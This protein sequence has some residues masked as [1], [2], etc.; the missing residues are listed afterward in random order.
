MLFKALLALGMLALS[1]TALIGPSIPL[2][3]TL[4]SIPSVSSSVHNICPGS[5]SDI[6]NQIYTQVDSLLI[7]VQKQ[8]LAKLKARKIKEAKDLGDKAALIQQF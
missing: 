5:K 4:A 6:I 2:P 3:S 8:Q 7:N 1:N